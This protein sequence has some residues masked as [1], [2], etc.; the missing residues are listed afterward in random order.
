[1]HHNVYDVEPGMLGSGLMIAEK[2]E[3]SFP[4]LSSAC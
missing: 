1:M 2:R 4:F 3:L